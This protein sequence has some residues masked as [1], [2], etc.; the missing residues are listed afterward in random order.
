VFKASSL[1]TLTVLVLLFGNAI[2]PMAHAADSYLSRKSILAVDL[3][4]LA[5]LSPE[6]L[7]EAS[8]I[9]KSI[10][11]SPKTYGLA[12]DSRIFGIELS[13]A[14]VVIEDGT[15]LPLLMLVSDKKLGRVFRKLDVSVTGQ[16]GAVSAVS[17]VQDIPLAKTHFTIRAGL[18]Q[19]KAILEDREHGIRKIYPLAAGGVDMGITPASRGR[20]GIMTP[21]FA[22]A[23]IGRSTAIASRTFPDYYR[24]LPFI[25]LTRADG[26]R[27]P[28]A[29]HILQEPQLLRGFESHG[30][31]RLREKDLNELYAIVAFGGSPTIQVDVTLELEE[32]D[33][34]PYKHRDDGYVAVR[35]CAKA[36]QKPRSCRDE[37]G[38]TI[39]HDVQ[40]RPPFEKLVG[41]DG[42]DMTPAEL[43][44]FEQG[45]AES[46]EE[47]APQGGSLPIQMIDEILGTQAGA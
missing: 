17:V 13:A 23:T 9:L 31:M 24:G 6:L 15:K 45:P 35:N 34:H 21:L 27:T 33:D 8:I 11:G 32:S 25:P 3:R 12:A 20:T 30:C 46:R 22:R 39:T 10:K 2:V 36:G 43:A 40:G 7:P 41:F 16:P 38:L 19:R 29:F 5:A 37:H 26:T 1:L 4:D 47:P 42:D 28:I 44:R 14:P 18:L